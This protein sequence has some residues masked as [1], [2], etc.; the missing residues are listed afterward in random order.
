MPRVITNVETTDATTDDVEMTPAIHQHLGNRRLA[1][2]E[3]VADADYVSAGHILAARTGHGITLPGPVG[4]DTHHTRRGGTGQE[5]ALDQ[6]AFRVDWD[7]RKV[8]CPQGRSASA[9]PTSANPMAP[10]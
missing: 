5:P 4:A 1:P 7:A 8:T 2:G 6:A 9:G 10:P 3:H